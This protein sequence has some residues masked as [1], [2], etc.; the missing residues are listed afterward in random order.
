MSK[1]GIHSY[2]AKTKGLLWLDYGGV[3]EVTTGGREIPAQ[4]THRSL[5][6]TKRARI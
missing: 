5:V 6:V 2:E 1:T 3:V 4:E